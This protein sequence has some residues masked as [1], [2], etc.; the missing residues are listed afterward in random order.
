MPAI[1]QRF[2]WPEPM[3]FCLQVTLILHCKR[4]LQ[5]VSVLIEQLIFHLELEIRQAYI[6]VE[7]RI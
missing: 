6:L 7:I 1:E 3:R 5:E 2:R 4:K